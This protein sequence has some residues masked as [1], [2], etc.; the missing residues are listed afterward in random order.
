MREQFRLRNRERGGRRVQNSRRRSYLRENDSRRIA[1]SATIHHK[2][3]RWGHRASPARPAP[4]AGERVFAVRPDGKHCPFPCHPLHAPSTA[5]VEK[6]A[7][8]SRSAIV[9]GKAAGFTICIRNHC[10]KNRSI[11]REDGPRLSSSSLH[12]PFD[13]TNSTMVRRVSR[14]GS[15]FGSF[16]Q[17]AIIGPRHHAFR[18]GCLR[19]SLGDVFLLY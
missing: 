6:P 16:V 11:Q 8:H 7:T 3:V 19:L 17:D 13:F 14:Q 9:L 1:A 4:L 12:L 2:A 18:N 10:G 15:Y 5:T